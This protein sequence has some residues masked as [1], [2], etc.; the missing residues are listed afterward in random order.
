VSNYGNDVILAEACGEDVQRFCKQEKAGDG[1]IH[2]CL[3]NHR[4]ELTDPC[5][6]AELELEIEESGNFDLRTSLRK[7]RRAS[8]HELSTR[9]TCRMLEQTCVHC[10]HQ[11]SSCTPSASSSFWCM[12]ADAICNL[13]ARD[14]SGTDLSDYLCAQVCA[15]ER[16]TFCSDVTTGKA[17]VFRCLVHNLGKAAFRQACHDEVLK[18]L[19]RRQQNWKLDV[20]LR[21]SCEE[22]VASFCAGVD[23]DADH[24]DVTRCLITH[25]QELSDGCQHEVRIFPHLPR[26]TFVR[27]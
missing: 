21:S 15:E 14:V 19:R 4:S 9:L 18:K 2:Q 12:G 24:A 16:Q 22:D 11:L 23:H 3:R 1:R 13:I 26:T 7:V 10:K 5:R 27:C 17:R 25:H 6:K 20:T 8:V